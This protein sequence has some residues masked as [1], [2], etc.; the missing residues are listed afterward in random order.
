MDHSSKVTLNVLVIVG[1]IGF[2]AIVPT[3]LL[4]SG[5]EF[6]VPLCVWLACH[7]I[8]AVGYYIATAPEAP[9]HN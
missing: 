7:A 9:N 3:K 5:R 1:T 2:L 8:A 4:F 6:L